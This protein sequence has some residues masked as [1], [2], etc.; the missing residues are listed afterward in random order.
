MKLT[1]KPIQSPEEL[2]QAHKIRKTVFV[3]EQACPEDIEWEFEDESNHYI[4][5]YDGEIVGT[6]RWRTTENG[7]K[8]ERF[9]IL[10]SYRN[11]KIGTALLKTMLQET[12]PLG[13][14]IYLHA[15]LHAASFYAKYGFVPDGQHFWEGGIEHVKMVYK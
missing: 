10:R 13:A 12:Q 9:A 1:V 14:K 7:I 11:K 15:Q 3:I 2:V 5:I 6:S 4:A 8:M